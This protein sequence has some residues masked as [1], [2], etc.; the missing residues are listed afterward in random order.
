MGSEGAVVVGSWFEPTRWDLVLTAKDHAHKDSGAALEEIYRTYWPA[1]YKFIRARGHAEA[2]AQDLT[3]EFFYHLQKQN[4]LSHL[5]HRQGK[6]RSFLLKFLTN[7][8]SDQRD[9]ATAQKRGGQVQ[10][11]SLDA[12]TQEESFEIPSAPGISP[13]ETYDRRWALAVSEKAARCLEAEYAK[14]G[15][16][17]LLSGLRKLTYRSETVDS[18]SVAKQLGLS[19]AALKSAVSRMRSRLVE[20]LRSEAATSLDPI[21]REQEFR[22]LVEVLGKERFE[23]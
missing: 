23:I 9:R 2:D 5:K 15:N 4:F 3:Q 17:D 14:N 21:E 19:E 22:Y 16:A 18:A 12:F 20:F 10:F 1:I 6:F 7:F 11:I 13:E 8:L